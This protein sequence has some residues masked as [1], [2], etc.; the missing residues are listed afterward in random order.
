MLTIPSALSV[1]EAS[2]STASAWQV[3]IQ[4]I[5]GG[6]CGAGRGSG[7]YLF[8]LSDAE[9]TEID[10]AK[11]W[12]FIRQGQRARIVVAD[13]P[14]GVVTLVEQTLADSD[15][16]QFSTQA[17]ELLDHIAFVSR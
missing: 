10:P 3:D 2:A 7:V 16:T 6:A 15:F 11:Q 12:V 14:A 9:I 5:G 4:A 13:L 8:P 17:G 1:P